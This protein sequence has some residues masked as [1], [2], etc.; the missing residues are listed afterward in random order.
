[1]VAGAQKV[2]RK[3]A[4]VG[5]STFCQQAVDGKDTK[6]AGDGSCA[7][8][9]RKPTAACRCCFTSRKTAE[10]ATGRRISELAAARRNWSRKGRITAATV[11]ENQR[12]AARVCRDVLVKKKHEAGGLNPVAEAIKI[13]LGSCISVYNHAFAFPELVAIPATKRGNEG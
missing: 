2:D 1:M 9:G 4:N 5:V 3:K 6:N 8:A 11:A 13:N 10:T 7:Y 12:V